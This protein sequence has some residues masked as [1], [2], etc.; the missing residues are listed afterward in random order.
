MPMEVE[1]TRAVSGFHSGKSSHGKGE[2]EGEGQ[3]QGWQGQRQ[4]QEGR[5]GMVKNDQFRGYCTAKGEDTIVPT[6]GNG[7]SK[8]GA[9]AAPRDNDGEVAAVIEVD[10]EGESL[11]WCFSVANLCA[12]VGAT[13]S[14]L[15]DRARR[16]NNS[17]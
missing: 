11:A 2:S 16:E 5:E 10:D 13:G 12:A 3:E 9:A 4:R 7:K 17:K 14:L 15:L 1:Q 8:G 6:A